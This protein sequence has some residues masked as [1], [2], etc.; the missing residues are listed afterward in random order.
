MSKTKTQTENPPVLTKPAFAI[1]WDKKEHQQRIRDYLCKGATDAEFSLYMGMARSYDLNPFKRE[2]HFVKYGHDANIVVGYE[3]YLK[4]AERTGK[5]DGWNVELLY[6]DK[7]TIIGSRITIHRKDWNQPFVWDIERIEFDT[8]KSTWLKRPG[9]MCKKTNIGQGFR[10]CFPDELGGLPYLPEEIPDTSE[11]VP[12]KDE[13]IIE[14]SPNDVIVE[15]PV[16]K[17]PKTE[18]EEFIEIADAIEE[19]E[20]KEKKEKPSSPEKNGNYLQPDKVAKIEQAFEKFGV[21]L[22]DIETVT[23]RPRTEW[24]ISVKEW[25]EEKW[26]AF[27]DGE[28]D[29]NQLMNISFN[30]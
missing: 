5:L 8:G 17:A 30:G 1:K 29:K 19:E 15:K 25:L 16:K 24:S 14:E 26:F 11:F 2:I 9:F 13:I 3:V 20:E 28:I 18:E 12:P 7:K 6:D 23:K 21:T 4:R 22:E 10:L 27:D